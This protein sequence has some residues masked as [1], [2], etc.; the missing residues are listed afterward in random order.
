[1]SV[2]RLF[3]PDPQNDRKKVFLVYYIGGV[4]FAE[5]SAL[6][7]LGNA[8]RIVPLVMMTGVN[9]IVATTQFIN[10]NKMVDAF[11]DEQGNLLNPDSLMEIY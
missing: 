11:K 4:T 10:G 5:I 3:Q 6:R 1:M 2:A 9:F 7:Y 8:L